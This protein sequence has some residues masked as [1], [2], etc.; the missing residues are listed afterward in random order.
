MEQGSLMNRVVAN[1]T[2]LD[3][4]PP[5]LGCDPPISKVS[6]LGPAL[7]GDLYAIFSRVVLQ[8]KCAAR[9]EGNQSMLHPFEDGYQL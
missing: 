7:L 3:S 1:A 8:L 2:P 6:T 5:L 9:K 4:T